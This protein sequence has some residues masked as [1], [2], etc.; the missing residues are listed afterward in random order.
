MLLKTADG[1]LMQLCATPV[2]ESSNVSNVN[3]EQ[4]TV[5][6]RT[7]P[8]LRCAVKLEPKKTVISRLS[9]AKMVTS[10]YADNSR[11]QDKSLRNLVTEAE[12][13]LIQE[14]D[15]AESKSDRRMHEN[16]DGCH[17]EEGEYQEND[18]SA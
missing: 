1:K 6:I 5:V 10:N 15:R 13:I 12:T 16:G 9:L 17:G 8:A 2:S 18:R 7:E 4:Q 11:F 14:C 3:T